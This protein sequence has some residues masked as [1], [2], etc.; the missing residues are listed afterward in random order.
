MLDQY[1]MISSWLINYIN[2]LKSSI[3]INNNVV[4]YVI[5]ILVLFLSIRLLQRIYY[6]FL[7]TPNSH[8]Q[9]IS[10]YPSKELEKYITLMN[11]PITDH[12]CYT[13][14]NETDP[15]KISLRYRRL[16]NRLDSM[17][18]CMDIYMIFHI[19]YCSITIHYCNHL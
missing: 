2:I 5:Y 17:I 4:A 12:I 11:I 19:F 3:Y 8:F 6:L 15:Q 16:G 1:S 7:T 14:N 10:Y 9:Y 18:K 13:V